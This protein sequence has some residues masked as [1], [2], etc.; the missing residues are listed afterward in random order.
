M[1]NAMK[2]TGNEKIKTNE[3]NFALGKTQKWNVDIEKINDVSKKELID[4]GC[5]ENIF[6]INLGQIKSKY[7]DSP[8]DIP[9]WVDIIENTFIRVT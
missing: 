1:V 6:K 3:F 4:A 5:A 2:I 7:K 8:D 9:D